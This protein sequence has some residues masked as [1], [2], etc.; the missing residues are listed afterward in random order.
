MKIDPVCKMQ[1][2]EETA[3]TAECDGE[4]YSFC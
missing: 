1:V 2:E 4:G 3:F